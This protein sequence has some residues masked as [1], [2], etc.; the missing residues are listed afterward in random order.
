MRLPRRLIARDLG[1]IALALVAWWGSHVLHDAG[2]AYAW[3]AALAAGLLIPLA[4]FLVHEWG[5]LAGARASGARVVYAERIRS[6][7]LFRFD[8]TR[9]DRRQFL[10][11][12]NG[13]FAASL[14]LLALLGTRLS[15][16]YPGDAIALGLAA[17]GVLATLV[18][19][20]PVAWRVW[21]GAALPSGA[22]FVS[23]RD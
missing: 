11:M 5:H 13:G 8:V 23:G 18:L 21:R 12:S 14:L 4:A 6:V 17:L 2:S 20:V 22:A 10:A 19:E 3:P 16:R 15:V 1:V 9:N 7:F